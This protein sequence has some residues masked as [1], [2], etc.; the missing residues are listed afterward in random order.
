MMILLLQILR[1][2]DWSPLSLTIQKSFSMTCHA[3]YPLSLTCYVV[4][5]MTNTS[6]TSSTALVV[7]CQRQQQEVNFSH[8]SAAALALQFINLWYNKTGTTFSCCM[9]QGL[10]GA[11]LYVL[12]L[13]RRSCRYSVPLLILLRQLKLYW[14]YD[15]GKVIVTLEFSV[16]TLNES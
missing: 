15:T 6:M 8:C 2:S 11:V 5:P 7:V 9:C 14:L 10:V 12:L 13:L 16:V 3:W 4:S 1:H